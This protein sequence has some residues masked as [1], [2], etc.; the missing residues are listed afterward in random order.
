MSED[1]RSSGTGTSA[2]GTSGTGTSG[3]GTSGTGTS[4]AGADDISA[5][6]GELAAVEQRVARTLEPGVR[7]LVVAVGVL[8]LILAM[9]LPHAGSAS[10]WDV[11][12]RS[13]DARVE[14]IGLTSTVF[15]WLALVAGVLASG[16]AVLTRRWVLA[17]LSAA[18]CAVGVVFGML[19]IWSRQTPLV[20]QVHAGPG[21]GLLL[22]W[23]VLLVL[24]GTW[25]RLVW[26]QAA[27]AGPQAPTAT[28]EFRPRLR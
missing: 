26:H 1:R 13:D 27:T 6:H 4:G 2:A 19:A 23:V 9:A 3:A 16:A 22:A 8:L 15:T 18:G 20:G 10:G 14:N 12:L 28:T 17:W 7:A 21:A 24:T 11:L 5:F 25:V